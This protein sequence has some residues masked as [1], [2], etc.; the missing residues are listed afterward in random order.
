MKKIYL[1]NLTGQLA[2]CAATIGFFDGVHL[3]HQYLIGKFVAEAHSR[4]LEAT[5]IT[6]D[7]HPRQVLN[8]DYRPQMINTLDE[9]LALL[10][11]TKVD[12]C[13]VLPF[14]VEMAS[15][16]A[17]DFMLTVLRDRLNVRLL[18]MG[19]DNRFGHN[20]NESFD[21]Y[22]AYGRELGMEV[23]RNDAYSIGV[24]QVNVSS[25]VIR[26]L[27]TEGEVAMAARCL[28]YPYA[29]SGEVVHGHNIGTGIGFPTANIQP[30]DNGKL[31]PANGVYAVQAIIHEEGTVWNGM[32]NIGNRP[33]FDGTSTALEVHL[34]EYNADL[35]GKLIT[36]VF[37]ERLREE[38]RF[39]NTGEL[40]N[41]LKRDEIE[42]KKIFSL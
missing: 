18:A 25:S 17:R 27:L 1:N 30:A 28:S 10:S 29:I 19:Y 35:Y 36:V 37:V 34:F 23:V 4:Q 26:S 41:Q 38:R 31:I 40:I 16:S 15:L 5:V 13:V 22:V 6:F 24:G 14:N 42:V 7:R 3:G 11:N 39:R 32:M 21:D 33:T 12:N 20:R 2:P 8:T 9:K